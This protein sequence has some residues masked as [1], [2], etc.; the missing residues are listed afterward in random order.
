MKIY[1]AEC[2]LLFSPP[3]RKTAAKRQVIFIATNS[4][5][6]VMDTEAPT[7]LTNYFVSECRSQPQHE[8]HFSFFLFFEISR[9][10]HLLNQPSFKKKLSTAV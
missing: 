3:T 10:K 2:L 7:A 6:E 9:F 1:E 8:T 4:H 5:W